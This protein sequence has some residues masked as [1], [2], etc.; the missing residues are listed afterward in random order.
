MS[1]I[2][3]EHSLIS[4]FVPQIRTRAHRRSESQDEG[5]V[6]VRAKHISATVTHQLICCQFRVQ[7]LAPESACQRNECMFVPVERMRMFGQHDCSYAAAKLLSK[8][9]LLRRS[10]TMSETKKTTWHHL[11]GLGKVERFSWKS[12]HLRRLEGN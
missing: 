4:S 12:Q 8:N 5:M 10:S 11:Q 7:T 3:V 9:Y 1:S 6:N 2:R